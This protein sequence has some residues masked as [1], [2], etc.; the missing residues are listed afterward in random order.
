MLKKIKSLKN[1]NPRVFW[2]TI[3]GK[4]RNTVKANIALL[5]N[6]FKTVNADD[7]VF[8]FT[9]D[10]SQ[11]TTVYNNDLLNAEITCE[12]IEH[13]INL[14]KNN[15]ACGIDNILNEHI[16][17]S[18]PI[19][20]DVY[21][22][23]FNLVFKSGIVPSNWTIGLINPIF[24]NKGSEND[25][26]NY[27]PITLLSCVS[28]LFTSVLNIRLEKFILKYDLIDKHQAGFRKHFSTADNMFVLYA[29]IN[30]LRTQKKKLFCAF[31]D[32]KAAFDTINRSLLWYKLGK[33][34]I[35]GNFLNIVKNMYNNA[36]SCIMCNGEKSNYFSCSVG[37][38]QGENL[39]PI[40]CSFFLN[41]LH[42][43]FNNSSDVDGINFH[44]QSNDNDMLIFFKLFVLLYADDTVIVAESANDLQNCLNVYSQYCETWKL[45]VNIDK[46]KIVIFS[47]GRPSNYVFYYKDHPIEVV[48]NY[49]YL[50]ILFNSSGS[51]F[52]DQKESSRTGNKS[53]VLSD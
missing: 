38:R 39:S 31:I 37:V 25:P 46:S 41:D 20:K 22:K 18:F 28:K 4:K 36:K 53:Y 23:L 3:S 10:E 43:Y 47:K 7:T 51:F 2:K 9:S 16:K 29:L 52:P 49:K 19:M 15:K 14:L 26:S 40:L 33:Y 50:G 42:S 8:D 27:R 12:E 30:I 11:P 17:A 35:N 34:S 21:V 13:C 5:E 45:T 44:V 48:R 32:L 6:H 24:K 1:T